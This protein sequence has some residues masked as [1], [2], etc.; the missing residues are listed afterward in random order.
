V[1][2][3]VR[4]G[5]AILGDIHR[6]KSMRATRC[7]RMPRRSG[8]YQLVEETP[9]SGACRSCCFAGGRH[10]HTS[11]CGVDDAPGRGRRIRG[12]GIFKSGNPAARAKAIVEATTHYNDFRIVAEVSKNLGERWS[13]STSARCRKVSSWPERMVKIGV[14][15]LQGDFIEHEHMLARLGAQPVEVRLPRDLDG[16][17]A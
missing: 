10:R 4:H 13:A 11:R 16:L 9:I 17:D 5:R 3:A 14:L 1:V 15:A 12:S 7:S 2:E 8:A 6:L